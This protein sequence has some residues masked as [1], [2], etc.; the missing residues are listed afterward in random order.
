MNHDLSKLV[1]YFLFQD[2]DIY[3]TLTANG[4]GY[5]GGSTPQSDSE[6]GFQGESFSGNSDHTISANIGG[7]GGGGGEL[8]GSG[9]HGKPGGG[10][11]YG[12]TGLVL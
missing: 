7:G 6:S 2:I 11:G 4:K 3:G 12:K 5:K 8:D 10:G 1:F 9:G